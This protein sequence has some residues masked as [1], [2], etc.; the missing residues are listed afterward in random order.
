MHSVHVRMLHTDIHTLTV[1]IFCSKPFTYLACL[2]AMGAD[3]VQ[4][5]IGREPS[6]RIFNEIVLDYNGEQRFKRT[7]HSK[8]IGPVRLTNCALVYERK[9]KED[10]EYGGDFYHWLC[11]AVCKEPN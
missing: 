2:E 7:S 5:F 3:R 4:S 1:S 6:G 8:F 11:T 10:T 9:I